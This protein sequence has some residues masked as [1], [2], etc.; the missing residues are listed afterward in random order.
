MN[1][2]MIESILFF[3]EFPCRIEALSEVSLDSRGYRGLL[4][5][6]KSFGLIHL[7]GRHRSMKFLISSNQFGLRLHIDIN[8]LGIDL[9]SIRL[10]PRI[11]FI[12][13]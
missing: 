7:K 9:N 10:Y 13:S 11:L 6:R 8:V 3:S 1:E 4:V 12:S 2:S 5:Q